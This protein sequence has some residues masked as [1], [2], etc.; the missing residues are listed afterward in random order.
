MRQAIKAKRAGMKKGV[1]DVWLPRLK[2]RHEDE[3]TCGLVG[4]MKAPAAP[5]KP[6][7]RLSAE[8]Q[9]WLAALEGEG[10]QTGVWYTARE[11]AT[12]I[13]DYLDSDLLRRN[14]P[15]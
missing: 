14:L 8:Q 4:E 9:G 11:A 2:W 12:A 6:K 7:G 1:P 13:A 5:G 10:W 15:D 3:V